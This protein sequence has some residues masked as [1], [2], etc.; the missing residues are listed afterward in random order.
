V[1]VFLTRVG[2][3]VFGNPDEWI[4]ASIS[5]ACEKFKGYPLDVILVN[6]KPQV[7]YAQWT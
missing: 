5:K 3:G 1:K 4:T 7:D 2:G 6:F